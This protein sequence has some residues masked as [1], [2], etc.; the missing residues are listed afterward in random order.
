MNN[1]LKQICGG[2][3]SGVAAAVLLALAGRATAEVPENVAATQS[4]PL[5]APGSTVE[6][7]CTF[8]VPAGRTL[9]SLLWT[10]SLPTGWTLVSG[11]VA[12]DGGP[13]ED[14]A[15]AFTFFGQDL[16]DHHP[17]RFSYRLTVPLDAM[18][19]TELGGTADYQLDGM[20]N[21]ERYVLPGA[22]LSDGLATQAALGYLAGQ[23]LNITC[24]FTH[25]AD[26]E[27]QSLLWVPELPDGWTLV[28]ASGQGDPLADVGR[29]DVALFGDLSPNPVTFVYTV[30]VAPGA[31]GT[32]YIGGRVDYQL[33]G[34]F[35]PVSTRALPDLLPVAELHTLQIVS[36]HGEPTPPVG[37]YT[38]FFGTTLTNRVNGSVTIGS[39]TF[40]CSGWTLAGQ[41]PA[42]GSTTNCVLT[43]T[44]NAVLTWVWVAPLI[45]AERPVSVTMDEDNNPA[46]PWVQ[47][48]ISAV[49]TSAPPGQPAGLLTWS[50]KTQAEHGA[51]VVTGSGAAPTI[52]YLPATNYFGGDSFV[53]QVSDGLGGVDMINVNVTVN[54]VND[55]PVLA[56]IGDRRTDERTPLTFTVSATDVDLLPQQLTYSLDPTSEAAGMAIHPTT[57]VF[58]W[59]PTAGQA[60]LD[61]TVFPVT[62]T[63]MDNGTGPANQRD[64]ETF[65]ITLDSSRATHTAIGYVAGLPLEITCTFVYPE[66]RALQTLL[67]KPELQ[68]G[69]TLLG[70]AGDGDPTV[71][72]DGAVILTAVGLPNPVTFRYTVRVPPGTIGPQPVGGSIE[73]TLDN[74]YNYSTIR[75]QP[76][77]LM[78]P[79]LLSLPKLHVAD[80]VYDGNTNATVVTYGDLAGVVPGHEG[81]SIVTD[82]AVAY[83]DAPQAGTNKTV[84]IAGLTLTGADAFWYAIAA[85][86]CTATIARA[87]LTVGG[88]FTAADKIYDGTTTAAINATGLTLLTPVTGDGVTLAAVAEFADKEVGANKTVSLS[89]ASALTGAAAG[90]YEL[91]L[92]GAPTA[93]AA[94]LFPAVSGTQACDGFR[95]PS[96]GT[97]IVNSFSYPADRTLT[98]LV[99]RPKLPTGWLL[100]AASG[101]GAPSVNNGT[102]IVFAGPFT[103]RPV[104]FS[105]TVSVP[106]NQGVTNYMNANVEFGLAGMTGTLTAGNLPVALLLRRYHS[107]DCFPPYWRI[108]SLELNKVK[109]YLN[110]G[111]YYV[112]P[113]TS[114]G[115]TAI[116]GPQSGGRHS[117]DTAPANWKISSIELNKVK[118]Y[119]N[120][121]GY[122]VSPGT[123]DGY[124]LGP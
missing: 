122:H 74:M 115:F 64:S 121:G 84:T 33:D 95:S 98:A 27:L 48:I 4:A 87:S 117:A 8:V 41:E 103:Q 43:L 89:A 7:S 80:K 112:D 107:A 57:G 82:A 38:N 20:F 88:A 53:V 77:P 75:A 94:I 91:S 123:S 19:P 47:P 60:G 70:A 5:Y 86:T 118:A 73:Y 69:W 25:R 28:G 61:F 76:D 58:T 45:S 40:A 116:P 93:T 111:A 29:G 92:V 49:T 67:W 99:W 15:G 120:A 100:V 51:A 114:D 13:L 16:G 46:H 23:P 21:P 65:A 50:L 106:G 24:T 32:N 54:P 26:R 83:F 102:E 59:T 12:G 11:S 63:V 71:G 124:A 96:A 66:G 72:T 68:E 3:V 18:G 81:V 104:A 90:N 44:Q 34:M 10:P 79:M 6:V 78:V 37:T 36:A 108:S 9:Q 14:G 85:Q 113:A 101:N 62:V 30:M 17:V 39:R 55:P 22:M 42:T 110:A 1:R 52:T 56:R 97:V 35:N 109:A 119:L 2:P 105:Y 31:T